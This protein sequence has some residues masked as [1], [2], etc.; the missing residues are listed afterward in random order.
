LLHLARNDN[1]HSI[2]TSTITNDAHTSIDPQIAEGLTVNAD[3]NF[4][5]ESSELDIWGLD[6][7]QDLQVD[8]DT[9][10]MRLF[11]QT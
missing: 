2:G 9:Q 11:A 4:V 3:A 8:W 5:D 1:T 10:D 6:F 7:I